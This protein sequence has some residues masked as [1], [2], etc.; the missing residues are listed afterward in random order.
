MDSA[1]YFI[2]SWL[3]AE[4]VGALERDLDGEVPDEACIRSTAPLGRLS[5]TLR[6]TLGGGGGGGGAYYRNW[7][8]ISHRWKLSTIT[9]LL[10]MGSYGSTTM[11]Q[12]WYNCLIY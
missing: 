11:C 4:R 10:K 2:V 8:V 9:T 7:R 6:Q 3:T 12:Y 5:D 1:S